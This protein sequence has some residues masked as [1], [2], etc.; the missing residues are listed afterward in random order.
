MSM[1]GASVGTAILA[2]SLGTILSQI[3]LTDAK[4]LGINPFLIISGVFSL[5][6]L[7]YQWMPETYAMKP[8]EQIEEMRPS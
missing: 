2:G 8:R 4:K 1:K 5:T 7:G 3:L 6:I